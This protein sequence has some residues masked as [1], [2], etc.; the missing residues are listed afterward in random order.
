[1]KIDRLDHVNLVTADMARM[2]KWYEAVMGLQIGPRPNFPVAGA[3]LYAGKAAV[4]HLVERNDQKRVGSEVGLKL[5]HFAFSASGM[6]K[7]EQ[8]LKKLGE[9]YDRIEL[10][11]AGTIQFHLSDPDGNH[12]HV[13]FD[14]A[15][16]PI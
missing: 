16:G 8:T 5:E 12:I 7:F 2:S 11:D 13:D 15:E 14:A 3:W 9:Q 4:V 6:A 10:R 1:M